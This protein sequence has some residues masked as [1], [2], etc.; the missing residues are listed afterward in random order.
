MPSAELA[1]WLQR[2]ESFH[3]AA[4]ELGLA[5][6]RQVALRLGC[7]ALDCPVVTVAGTNGKGSTVAV[8]EQ[9]AVRAGL[10]VGT[11][12]SPHLLTYNERV[13]LQGEPVADQRLIAA[14][15]AIDRAR[16]GTA[17]TYFEFS[18]L[19]ALS[20]FAGQ[21]L[22]LA[23]LEVGLGG[24]LDAVNLLDPDIAIITSI[25][26]DHE[27][28]LGSNREQIGREK[29]GILRPGIAVL[30]ADQEPP[31]SVLAYSAALGCRPWYFSAAAAA[32]DWPSSLCP[33]NIAAAWECSR[34]LGFAPSAGALR[35]LLKSLQLPGRLQHLRCGE[36]RILLDVGHNPAATQRLAQH[37]RDGGECHRVALFAALA[38]KDIHAM[39]R[40]CQ[41]LFAGWY[42]TALPGV[43]RANA[44]SALSA[45]LSAAGEQLLG[46]GARP[47]SLLDEAL[48]ALPGRGQLVV[49]GSFYT[50]AAVLPRLQ[51]LRRAA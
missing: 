42:V 35:T 15:V 26:L 43:A 13:R 3:P 21:S 14:F 46:S 11:Y 4:I 12:T 10:R 8:L 36:Q 49:F 2:L 29:A 27:S 19:A 44:V 37:L 50:V 28:W 7:A 51:E 17:L 32:A 39:I 6:V 25:S 23:V 33:E 34:Q 38:D 5:R 45:A 41:G 48:Q 16:Q 30:I 9:I 47:D 40:S 1:H 31:R 24:R 20:I 22:D 18:T